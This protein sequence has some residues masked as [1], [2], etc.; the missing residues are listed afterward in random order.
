MST[1]FIDGSGT[2]VLLINPTKK[3]ANK[4]MEVTVSSGNLQR[5]HTFI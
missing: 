3:L 2:E 5:C 1:V 4:I